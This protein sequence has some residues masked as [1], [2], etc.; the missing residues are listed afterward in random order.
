MLTDAIINT[1]DIKYIT[2]FTKN[3]KNTNI[4]KLQEYLSKNENCLEQIE[5]EN[6]KMLIDLAK[7]S[8]YDQI[9]ENQEEFT[10]LFNNSKPKKL[11]KKISK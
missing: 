8:N 4:D 9:K 3:V 11:I 5:Q 6:Y 10:T 7:S 2:L 1:G